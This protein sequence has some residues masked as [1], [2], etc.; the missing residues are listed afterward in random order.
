MKIKATWKDGIEIDTDGKACW[1][2]VIVSTGI[3]VIGI[4][5][6]LRHMH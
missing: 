3:V 5:G 6:V 2:S 4:L 1:S